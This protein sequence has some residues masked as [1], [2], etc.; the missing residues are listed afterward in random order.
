MMWAER[1]ADVGTQKAKLV[2]EALKEQRTVQEIAADHDMN[3]NLLFKWRKELLDHPERAFNEKK[4]ADGDGRKEEGV[5]AEKNAMP[6]TIGTPTLERDCLRQ[7]CEKLGIGPNLIGPRIRGVYWHRAQAPLPTARRAPRE[8]MLRACRTQAAGARGV[9]E[10]AIRMSIID[11]SHIDL[12][13]SGARKMARECTKRG[14]P[15]TRCRAQRPMEE[16]GIRPIYPKP[17]TSAPAK[18]RPKSLCLLRGMRIWPPNRVWAT[19][20]T[21]IELGRAHMHLGAIVGWAARMIVGWGLSDALEAAPAVKC[22]EKAIRDHGT[23]ATANT[24]QG[25]AYS[26]DA[27]A[28]MLARHGIRQSMDGRDRWADNVVMERWRR[29]L[30]TEWLRLQEYETPRQLRDCI[31]RFV[32]LCNNGRPHESLDYRTPAECCYEAFAMAA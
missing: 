16:T 15:T 2:I 8:R 1:K 9:G 29:T 24:D 32:D 22:F 27:F 26:A 14:Y 6:R 3:P 30:K 20:I 21:R 4:R 19:G 18:R 25:S 13:A 28:N 11:D 12:P 7:S 31:A 23:P 10:K 17:S 5:A